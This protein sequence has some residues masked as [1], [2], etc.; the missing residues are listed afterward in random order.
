[1]LRVIPMWIDMAF[2]ILEFLY[3]TI[4]RGIPV[5]CLLKRCLTVCFDHLSSNSVT[6][7]SL[8]Q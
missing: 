3:L 1:M 6:P 7:F 8:S 5:S 2:L 4:S